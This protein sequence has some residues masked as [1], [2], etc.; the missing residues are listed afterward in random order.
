MKKIIKCKNDTIRVILC[1][2]Y[3]QKELN[4]NLGVGWALLNDEDL[5]ESCVMENIKY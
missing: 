2:N 1:N 5:K 3:S 4:D